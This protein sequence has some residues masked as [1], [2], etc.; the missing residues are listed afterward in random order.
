[1][2]NAIVILIW[3]FHLPKRYGGL[4][5]WRGTPSHHVYRIFHDKPSS[6]WGYPMTMETPI[7]YHSS[8][9]SPLLTITKPM[10][11]LHILEVSHGQ[12]HHPSFPLKKI[13]QLFSTSI[14]PSWN[15]PSSYWGYP[16]K[17]LK[18][19]LVSRYPQI[20]KIHWDDQEAEKLQPSEARFFG[21]ILGVQK[22]REI[23]GFHGF[24]WV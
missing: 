10:K 15:H 5:K 14:K 24:K 23:G 6:Y 16:L 20:A 21:T 2:I 12:N 17:R 9:F 13:T 11:N 19:T 3:Q 7:S 8:L 22:W 1:M 4:L 18:G